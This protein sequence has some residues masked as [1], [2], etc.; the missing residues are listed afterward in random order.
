MPVSLLIACTAHVEVQGEVSHPGWGTVC[1]TAD[2][3]LCG[4]EPSGC[5][6]KQMGGSAGSQ[7]VTFHLDE[8]RKRQP[9]PLNMLS[10]ELVAGDNVTTEITATIL[11]DGAM[12]CNATGGDSLVLTCDVPD[13]AVDMELTVS[14]NGN[15]GAGMRDL[16]WHPPAGCTFMAENCDG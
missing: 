13:D 9:Y 7:S 15:F 1:E 3:P 14:S 11:F 16:T 10:L 5:I 2:G 12:G 6:P 8:V 4:M